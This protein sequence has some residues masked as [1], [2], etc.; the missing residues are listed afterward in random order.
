MAAASFIKKAIVLTLF[1]ICGAFSAVLGNILYNQ[2]SEGLHHVVKPFRKPWFQG[3]SMFVAMS[4]LIFNTD[5]VRKC[6]CPKYTLGGTVRGWGLFRNVA[7]PAL[8]DLIATL[9][10]NIAL[11]YLPP[12]VWQM[13][14]GSILIF[15]AIFA[16]TYRKQKLICV[17]WIGVVTTVVGI[18]IV[19][20][21]AIFSG[22]KM[23]SSKGMMILS[24]GLVIIAQA[25]QAFQT[26]IEEELLHD[27]DATESEIVSYEGLWGFF[28]STF[29]TLP[30][31]NIVPEGWGEGL[32]EQS[33]ETFVMIGN[34][35]RIILILIAY[36]VVILGYNLT[37]MMVTSFSTA[38]HRNI[39]EAL[40]SAAVWV[41]SVIVNYIAPNSG[42]GEALTYYSFLQLAGFG[43]SI[44]GSFIYNR[45][46]RFKC[47]KYPDQ[48][49][50][51]DNTTKS[52]VDE[53]NNN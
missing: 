49:D 17:D 26:I 45:V 46:L 41:L 7:I 25:L 48:A 32:Y 19:G 5:I 1:F 40:R 8:C 28:F 9:L 39:Y 10:Q 16:I 15:T 11:L 12:S 52:L 38:I 30:L 36:C 44:L 34:S 18:T 13:F 23:T 27:V 50:G 3:W 51:T 4:C 35:W 43:L 33:V 42:A 31:A 37:G 22:T 14:R 2:E 24:M 29:I 6:R 47:L 21:S 20:T 53:D